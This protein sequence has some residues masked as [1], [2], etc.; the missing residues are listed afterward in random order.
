VRLEDVR[1]LGWGGV[2]VVALL[3]LAVRPVGVLLCTLGSELSVRER[4]FACWI[5]PREIVAAAMASVAAVALEGQGMAGGPELRALVF[6]TI[7]GTVVLAG[8]TSAPVARLLKVRI[9]NRDAVAILGAQGL[10][11]ELALQLRDGRNRVFFIDSNPLNCRRA[12]ESGFQVFY[13]DAMQERTMQRARFESVVNAIGLTSNQMVNSVFASRA[14]EHFDVPRGFVAALN[15]DA[16]LAPELVERGEVVVLF[17][18]PHDVERWDVRARHDEIEIESWVYS[19]N[20]ESEAQSENETDDSAASKIGE[21]F[22]ILSIRRGEKAFVMHSRLVLQA[23]DTAAVA[24]HKDDLDTAREIL[25][26][27]GWEPVQ[28]QG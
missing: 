6:L 2:G 19:G 24:I 17:E 4:L 21:R 13:G 11:L 18:G 22:V 26:A 9:P 27:M 25:T 20:V 7:A 14:R 28:A 5:A 3:V 16:G 10:G 8:L 15:P 23:G 1:A 12:E